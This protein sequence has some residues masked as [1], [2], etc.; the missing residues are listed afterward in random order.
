VR[1]EVDK[2]Q[3]LTRCHKCGAKYESGVGVDASVTLCEIL[4]DYSYK[5]EDVTYENRPKIHRETLYELCGKCA[6][7]FE[8]WLDE[9]D[10]D[11]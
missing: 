10:G 7:L 1:C 4:G 3:T 9:R 8:K 11:D 5:G 6:H 2:Y